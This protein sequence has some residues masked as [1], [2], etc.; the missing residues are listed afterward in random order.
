[1]SSPRN[2]KADSNA[3]FPRGFF[4]RPDMTATNTVDLSSFK[5]RKRA[6]FRSRLVA[7]CSP[8]NFP[9]QDIDQ[10][11]GAA[12]APQGAADLL[13]MF[14]L[15][16]ITGLDPNSEDFDT[17][18]NTWYQLTGNIFSHLR[19]GHFLDKLNA[20]RRTTW[21]PAYLQY[22]D[23]LLAADTA[24]IARGAKALGIIKGIPLGSPRLYLGPLPAPQ[25]L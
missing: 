18:L 10:V 19:T 22:V 21:H 23:A 5:E 4:L 12:I 15:F 3:P 13:E 24:G 8:R 20:A 9:K 6:E 17:V 16:G 14:Q 2:A 25:P 7:L 11:T 1:M